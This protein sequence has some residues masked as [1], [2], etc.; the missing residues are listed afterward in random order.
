M[1][2]TIENLVECHKVAASRGLFFAYPKSF[3]SKEKRSSQKR[4]ALNEEGLCLQIVL[5]S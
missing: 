1:T 4:R 3:A 5:K 2:Q